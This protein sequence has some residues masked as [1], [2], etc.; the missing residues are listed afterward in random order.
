MSKPTINQYQS[1]V[2]IENTTTDYHGKIVKA[3]K[4]TVASIIP[5]KIE[6]AWTFVQTPKLLQFVAKGMISFKSTKGH[7]P[8]KWELGNT[9]GAK[10]KIFGF[11]P[12][13]GTHYLTIAKIDCQNHILS[14]KEWD[15]NAK[16]WNHNIVMKDLG[17]SSI[18]YE[19]SIIIYGGFMTSFITQFAKLFYK[20][21]QRRW[22]IVA[23]ENI[24][25]GA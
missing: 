15:I 23:K 21:R 14:T 8:E 6:S 22:Q 19:D 2:S 4:L 20:H 18:Y 1:K 5:I 10:M 25:F 24:T 3:K 17:N 9:Y 12:F 13:G 16:I 7:F 11:F